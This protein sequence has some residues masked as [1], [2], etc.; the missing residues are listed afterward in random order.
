[1]TSAW[2]QDLNNWN[3]YI[4]NPGIDLEKPGIDIDAVDAE[5]ALHE[6]GD[7]LIDLKLQSGLSARQVC[8]LCWW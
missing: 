7:M 6:A 3:G 5:T 1:M 2:E 8:T 4:E